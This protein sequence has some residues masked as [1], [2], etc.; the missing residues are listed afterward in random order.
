MGDTRN[1][2]AVSTAEYDRRRTKFVQYI[3]DVLRAPEILV[4]QEV[5]KIEVLEDLAVDISAADGSVVYTAY[6][7]E[8]NDIVTIDIGFLVRENLVQ[9]DACYTTWLYRDF[10]QSN[11]F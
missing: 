8:G 7:I 11:N 10:R 1:D 2:F 6:L 4:V 3:L 5:E 9:V